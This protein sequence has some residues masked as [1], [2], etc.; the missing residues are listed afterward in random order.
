MLGLEEFHKICKK[1]L[2]SKEAS[3]RGL[4]NHS[5]IKKQLENK[6]LANDQKKAIN[7]WMLINIELFCINYID[8]F[9]KTILTE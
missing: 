5:E 3:T 8:N 7:I 1:I 9:N 6:D 2:L 4:Y